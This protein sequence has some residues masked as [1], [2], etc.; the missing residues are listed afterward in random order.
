M[1]DV[2]VG[3]IVSDE[4]GVPI[5]HATLS[6]DANCLLV[7][8][9][10]DRIRLLDRES[11]QVLASYKGHRNRDYRIVSTLSNDDAYVV[12]GSEDGRIVVWDLVECGVVEDW[13]AHQ[14][15]TMCTAYHPTEHQ[16]SSGGGDGV[17][18]IWRTPII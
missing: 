14:R 4:L 1:Y 5:T 10:D 3:S 2:R 11:G 16:I 17:L 12:S 13:I 7:S 18:N 15:A 8:S 9:L 6:N